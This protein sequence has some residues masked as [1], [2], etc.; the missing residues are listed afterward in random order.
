M[1]PLTTI[2][3]F[4][5]AMMSCVSPFSH[6]TF[7]DEQVFAMEPQDQ[8][9]VVGTRV[10]LPCRVLHKKGVLQWTKDD[11]GLG[12]RRKLSA[13]ERYTM[14]GSDDEGDYSLQIFPVMLDDEARYQCQVGPGHNGKFA[15]CP[16]F[17]HFFCF[18]PFVRSFV[19][20][21]KEEKQKYIYEK[22][23][24]YTNTHVND[25]L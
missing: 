21:H 16:N 3:T 14:I 1:T 9:A 8:V 11:F 25:C 18:S 23:V 12:T 6:L 17:R 22:N 24:I 15:H 20:E 2:F 4:V 5:F 7:D 19:N 13:F 10:I